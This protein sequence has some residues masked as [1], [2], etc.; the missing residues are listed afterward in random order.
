MVPLL[1][2]YS[3]FRCSFECQDDDYKLEEEPEKIIIEH[4]HY[5][6]DFW[7]GGTESNYIQ[8]EVPKSC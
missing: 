2:F 7:D 6:W 5:L 4:K 3:D 8:H 1:L